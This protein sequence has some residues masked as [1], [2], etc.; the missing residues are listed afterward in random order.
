MDIENQFA[1]CLKSIERSLNGVKRAQENGDQALLVHWA[2]ALAFWARMMPLDH[3][4]N[5]D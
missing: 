4:K 1:V 3:L 2:E 5:E